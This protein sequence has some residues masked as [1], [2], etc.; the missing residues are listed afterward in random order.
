MTSTSLYSFKPRFVAVLA[1]LA[2]GLTRR[3]VTPNRLTLAAI[4]LI[5]TTGLVLVLG[6]VARPAWL[7]APALLLALMGVNALDGELAR[8]GGWSSPVGAALNELVDRL[9]D[10]VILSAGFAF[11]PAPIVVL[12]LVAVS[13]AETVALVGWGV[14]GVRGLVG[15]MGKPDRALIVG[16][17]AAA[18]AVVGPTP[19]AVAYGIIA[20]GALV[21]V[22]QRTIWVVRHAR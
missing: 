9:G 7:A 10:V 21:S 4:P 20:A 12:A 18:A 5:L 22:G 8:R 14:S 16:V 11:A 6:S 2:P 19:L 17:G 1:R 13:A 3:G 15:V